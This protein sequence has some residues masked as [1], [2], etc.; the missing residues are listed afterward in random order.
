[1]SGVTLSLGIVGAFLRLLPSTC[2]ILLATWAF[3]KSSP[4]F[5]A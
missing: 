5:H 4:T 1:M 3:T 2:F